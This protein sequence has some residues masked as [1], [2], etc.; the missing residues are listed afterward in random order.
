MKFYFALQCKRLLRSFQSW[1]MN[2]YLGI[3]LAVGAFILISTQFYN[4]ISYWQYGYP[5]LAILPA[6]S[7]GNGKRNQ[8]L[9]TLFT[10]NAY[11]TL[12]AVENFLVA[13]PFAVFLLIKQ[14]WLPTLP[15][16]VICLL[17][18]FYNNVGRSAFVI[19]SPFYKKPFE[20]TIG[21]RKNYLLITVL[22]ILG[23]IALS[24]DNFNLGMLVLLVLT[25][26]CMNF[27]ATAEPEFY[28][29]VHALTPKQFLMSKIKTALTYSVFT[30]LPVVIPYLVWYPFKAYIPV[31]I[32]FV[33]MLYVITIIVSKYVD[34]PHQIKLLP[35][36]K[37]SLGMIFPPALF[38]LIPHFYR[39]SVKKLNAYLR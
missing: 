27:Y 32:L 11:L 19:P 7:L 14:Q 22:Y 10:K 17:M 25:L 20:F 38:L 16:L 35:T 29:W 39:Q 13:I 36:L 4:R 3:L 8:F 15:T 18:S 34:Y 30:C 28:V 5:L 24:F 23:Y 9:K 1:G 26:V 12:R 2:P 31:I 37:I 6:Y 33:G 21:F